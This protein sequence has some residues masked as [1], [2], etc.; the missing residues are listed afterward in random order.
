MNVEQRLHRAL[1]S[2]DRIEPSDDL[3]TRVVHSID[4]DRAH[5][6][7]VLVSASIS[8]LVLI[9]L[10]AI[11]AASMRSGRYGSYVHRPTMEVLEAIGLAAIVL[12]LGPAIRRFGRHYAEDLFPAERTLAANMLRSLDIGYYLVFTAYILM[13]TQFEFELGV[14]GRRAS[15]DLAEQ[16]A[17]AAGR[18]GGLLLLMGLL[19]AVTLI[20]LPFIALVH[21]STRRRRR[22]PRWLSIVGIIL[23]GW[24]ALQTA[25]GLLGLLIAGLG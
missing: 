7:R 19:H 18:L 10:A 3:W 4:E 13:S 16:L 1:H 5:R 23:V 15:I 22:L 14:A 12:A 25:L 9:G 17:A 2:V 24:I 6:R 8:L 20:A 11:G 21:N